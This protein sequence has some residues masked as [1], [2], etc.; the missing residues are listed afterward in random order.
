MD[1]EL[2]IK[3]RELIGWI[4]EYIIMETFNVQHLTALK[5]IICMFNDS[6]E[7]EKKIFAFADEI[8]KSEKE[9]NGKEEKTTN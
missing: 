5:H 3:R 6:E 9:I 8:I 4:N 2:I 1:T 7:S